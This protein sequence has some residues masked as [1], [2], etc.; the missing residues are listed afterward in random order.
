MINDTITTHINPLKD[1]NSILKA[2]LEKQKSI[3]KELQQKLTDC[4]ALSKGYEDLS[5]KY[6]SLQLL[7]QHT[8]DPTRLIEEKLK[9]LRDENTNTQKATQVKNHRK[10]HWANALQASQETIGISGIQQQIKPPNY[11]Y[12]NLV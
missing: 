4:E 7:Q 3:S 8:T 12:I 6:E 9:A 2:E 11:P 10:R 5:K 1:E